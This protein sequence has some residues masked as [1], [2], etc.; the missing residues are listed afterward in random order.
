VTPRGIVL[1]VAAVFAALGMHVITLQMPPERREAFRSTLL[2]LDAPEVA[3][4]ARLDVEIVNAWGSSVLSGE[5]HR[6]EAGHVV[7]PCRRL[8]PGIYYLRLR[9]NGILRH[10]YQLL[11]DQR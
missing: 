10:E 9:E 1:A 8:R 6:G 3:P 11:A 5:A 7:F 2:E 4:T